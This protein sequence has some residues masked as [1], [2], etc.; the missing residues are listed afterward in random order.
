MTIKLYVTH[1]MISGDYSSMVCEISTVIQ[2]CK[3]VL[4]MEIP[5]LL[6]SWHVV[7]IL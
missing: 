4:L 7:E 1:L 5:K 6:D 3:D 2:S